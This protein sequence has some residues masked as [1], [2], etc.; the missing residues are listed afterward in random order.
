M[1]HSNVVKKFYYCRNSHEANH[2]TI[3][4]AAINYRETLTPF[5]ALIHLT[6]STRSAHRSPPRERRRE[7]EEEMEV[8]VVFPQI[9]GAFYKVSRCAR[10]RVLP[11]KSRGWLSLTSCFWGGTW[12]WEGWAYH[13]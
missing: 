3:L 1:V 5:V 2:V 6:P 10:G 13:F 11:G 7:K 4:S 9:C 8:E 12:D